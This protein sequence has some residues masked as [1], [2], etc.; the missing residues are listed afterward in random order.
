MT[1]DLSPL[2]PALQHRLRQLSWLV[3]YLALPA[4]VLEQQPDGEL[5]WRNRCP[6]CG[7]S[8][9]QT[10][11]AA[12]GL[13]STLAMA[14]ELAVDHP[15]TCGVAIA[16][17]LLKHDPRIHRWAERAVINPEDAGGAHVPDS[18]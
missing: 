1:D 9:K 4:P 17:E 11:A 3:R 16:Q 6:Y 10:V 12:T 13:R 5:A 15:S 14:R 18:H 2:P 8:S 7:A